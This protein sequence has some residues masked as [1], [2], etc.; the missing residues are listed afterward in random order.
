MQAGIIKTFQENRGFGFI[1]TMDKTSEFFFCVRD[2]DI[3]RDCLQT[4]QM[5]WFDIILTENG[6]E[7]VRVQPYGK[8]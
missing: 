7:A 6:P 8:I 4:G 2:L 5:V 1:T 3:D